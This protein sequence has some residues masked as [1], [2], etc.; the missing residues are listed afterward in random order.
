VSFDLARVIRPEVRALQA[1]EAPVLSAGPR[2]KLDANESPFALGE[3]VRG[4]L[5]AELAQA[6]ADVMLHRYPDP[7]ARDVRAALAAA[8][9]VSAGQIVVTNGSDEAI[10]LLEVA[11]A[12][13]RAAVLAPVPTFVMY[14]LISRALGLAVSAVPLTD[15][16][17]LDLDAIRDA[18]RRDQPRIVFLAW[19]NN[20]TGRLFDEEKVEAI[21]RAA[22][23][24]AC[25]A[26]VVVDEAYHD[27][28]GKSF[29]DRLGRYPNLVILRT[30]SK[31]G[32]A[33]IRL[34]ALI[35]SPAVVAEVNKARLPYNVNALSQAAARV[36]LAHADLVRE[37]VRLIVAERERLLRA[38]AGLPGLSVFPSDANFVLMRT[39]RPASDVAAALLEKGVAVRDFSRSRFLEDCL[40]VTVGTPAENAAFL[41]ALPVAV[42]DGRG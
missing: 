11:V 1:Y 31:I 23:G 28:A 27:Y 20:P 12:G 37:N 36:V 18:L 5:A 16:F 9:G 26:L 32:L 7:T 17:D 19:P 22:G 10:Q 14:E 30:L 8:L 34:G 21:I 2:V 24:E 39:A 42:A 25:E 15:A 40:R 41:A 3:A 33:G 13:P 6:L 35:A 38:L 4:A 29:L